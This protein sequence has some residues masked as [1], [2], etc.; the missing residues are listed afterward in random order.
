MKITFEVCDKCGRIMTDGRN[1]NIKGYKKGIND[2]EGFTLCWT[3]YSE[4]TSVL[5]DMC[6]HKGKEKINEFLAEFN[7]KFED[8]SI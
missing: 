3:C 8:P 6:L 5:N 7:K 4:I 1:Y 2:G